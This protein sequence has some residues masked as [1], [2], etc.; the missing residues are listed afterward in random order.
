M[1]EPNIGLFWKRRQPGDPAKAAQVL[2]QGG[3]YEG[4]SM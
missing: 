2:L 1:D 4:F 3:N